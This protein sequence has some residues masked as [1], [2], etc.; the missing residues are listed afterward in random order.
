MHMPTS[1]L[2]QYESFLI[3]NASTINTIESSLRSLTWFLPGR[4]KDAELASESLTAVL[5]LLGIYHDTLLS[6]QMALSGV[7]PLLPPAPHTKYIKAWMEKDRLYKWAARILQVLRFTELMVEMGLRRKVNSKAAWRGILTIETMKAVLRLLIIKTTKRPLLSPTVPER[8]V[9]PATF[10]PPPTSTSDP[11][12]VT[13]TPDHIKNNRIQTPPSKLNPLLNPDHTGSTPPIEGYLLSKALTP[14]A[15]KPPS[16][17]ISPLISP[18]DWIAEVLYILRPLIYVI[19]LSRTMKSRLPSSQPLMISIAIDVFTRY[20]RRT[21]PPAE[22]L[23]R[24]EYA[25]RDRD[26][27]WYFLRGAIWDGFTRPK[28]EGLAQKTKGTPLLSVIS[29]LLGDYLP[30]VDEYYYYSAT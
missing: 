1:M 10:Q 9:D 29:A 26:L 4:F 18:K 27:F 23:E 20:I 17:I 22:T 30:L 25:R 12:P 11:L 15:V 24:L 5:N 13:A 14:T 8:E 28:L 2:S 16:A 19:A 21:P 6:R 7:K 3:Q